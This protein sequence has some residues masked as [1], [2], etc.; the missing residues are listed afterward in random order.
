MAGD[1]NTNTNEKPYGITN[2]KTYIP[3]MLDLDELNYDSWSELFTLH[4]KSFGVL[5][6]IDGTSPSTNQTNDEWG[7]LD[8]LVKLWI[9][10]TISK[11][12][13]QRVLKKNVSTHD[14]WKML[15][16]VFHDNKSARAMQL[17][18]DLRNIEL[19]NL[20]ITEYFHKINRLA[21]LLA[22]IDAPVD[23]K[24]L[25]AYAINGL[26]DKYEH[27]AGIIRHRE[28]SPTFAQ[29]QSMLLLE[30]SRLARKTTR[31]SARDPTSSSPHVLLAAASNNR[32]NSSGVPLCRNFQRGSCS[33]GERCKY[34][35]NNESGSV[36]RNGNGK[37]NNRGS[38]PQMNKTTGRI[39]HGARM[40][41]SPTRP[42]IMGY[43]PQPGNIPH[44]SQ[45]T[46]GSRG[47]LG[48]AHGQAHV[49]QPTTPLST[50][51]AIFS[52][53]GPPTYTTRPLHDTWGPQIIYGPY[54]DQVTTLS[55][56]FNAMTVQDYGG[57]G[58]Y[59][60]TGETSHLA[61]DTGKLTTISN[62]SNI[63]SILVGNGNSIPVINSGHSML[64]TP[65]NLF[66]YVT[67]LL[68]PI[69]SK[70]SYQSVNLPLIMH[71]LLNL[72]RLVFL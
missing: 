61:S 3:L 67:F 30:E 38:S 59:M 42:T 62:N 41:F 31:Q 34:V 56:A 32:T 9:F 72:I 53:S 22:N 60:D 16:D 19:R 6:L 45:A 27:V 7:K 20:T 21:D 51:P 48:P 64:P 44:I 15:K 39:M 1:D 55:Q 12:L 29:T 63:S 40:I 17:D 68:H 46:F 54:V 43:A 23:E 36:T 66:T 52:P 5:H 26:G 71:A 58:W 14:V 33:F 10:G 24:N 11:P 50:G 47:V 49:T 2:I 37:T 70:T 8:S 28:T 65:N 35:H 57:S 4:C 18:N 69:I 13:L 25:V